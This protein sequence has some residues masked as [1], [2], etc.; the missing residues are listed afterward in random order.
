MQGTN[1]TV[2]Q[3][4]RRDNS[5]GLTADT[6]FG[7]QLPKSLAGA[8]GSQGSTTASPAADSLVRL[9]Q[10]SA[11]QYSLL[12][13]CWLG[14]HSRPCCGCSQYLFSTA[15]SADLQ[16]ICYVAHVECIVTCYLSM[17]RCRA[18]PVYAVT[19]LE[20]C[21]LYRVSRFCRNAWLVMLRQHTQAPVLFDL[22]NITRSACSASAG[23]PLFSP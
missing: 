12:S 21:T 17:Q 20:H 22:G 1:Q 16:S 14:A 2:G 18:W 10:P 4:A 19:G 9:S 23:W 13:C 7:T 3:Q 15:K 6:A 5:I 11:R 8:P